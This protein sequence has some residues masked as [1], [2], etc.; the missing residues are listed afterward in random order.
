VAKTQ[1]RRVHSFKQE[2]LGK[3]REAALSGSEQESDKEP[4]SRG[5]PE[6]HEFGLGSGHALSLE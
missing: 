3:S 6:N 5:F 4:I 1:T 2:L